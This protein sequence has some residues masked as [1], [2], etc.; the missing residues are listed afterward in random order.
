MSPCSR[1][2]VP[3]GRT[4][5][6]KI[7]RFQVVTEFTLDHA[8]IEGGTGQPRGFATVRLAVADGSWLELGPLGAPE[9]AD[10]FLRTA[11]G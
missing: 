5:G 9:D 11:S 2:V 7:S 3:S 6:C 1:R 10:H 8:R 4:G